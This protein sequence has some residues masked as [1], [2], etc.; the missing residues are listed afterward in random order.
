VQLVKVCVASLLTHAV[1]NVVFLA[2]NS[3]NSLLAKFSETFHLIYSLL[4]RSHTIRAE[5][6]FSEEGTGMLNSP[7][8]FTIRREIL[9]SFRHAEICS[10]AN[11]SAHRQWRET[12][13]N[14]FGI[15]SS[16]S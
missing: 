9:L 14:K 1:T 13:C 15:A 7:H 5:K 16:K 3:F 10:A 12:T 2:C 8:R 4:Q 6:S 11:S